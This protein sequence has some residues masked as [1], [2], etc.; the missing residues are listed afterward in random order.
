M[1]IGLIEWGTPGMS[2]TLSLSQGRRLRVY[3]EQL[4]LIWHG[5]SKCRKHR[6]GQGRYRPFP[7]KNLRVSVAPHLS[8]A[9]EKVSLV[10]IPENYNL[11]YITCLIVSIANGI[12]SAPSKDVMCFLCFHLI[13][14]AVT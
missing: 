3:N 1:I 10:G 11:L 9:S 6:A 4:Y 5:F 14:P 12:Q 13:Q 2:K 8:Q 7:P